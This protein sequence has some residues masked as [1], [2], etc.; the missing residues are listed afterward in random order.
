MRVYWTNESYPE[1]RP[2]P[3]R[4][5]RHR[6]WW[7]AFWLVRRDPRIYAFLLIVACILVVF[8]WLTELLDDAIRARGEAEV[9]LQT[10]MAVLAVTLSGM[11][12]LTWGGYIMRLHL[13]RASDRCRDCCPN[14]GYLLSGQL[15]APAGE[16]GTI[17]CPECGTAY[18]ASE[19]RA[20]QRVPPP[21]Q[22]PRPRYTGGGSWQNQ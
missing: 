5:L 11:L 2:L 16:S 15:Q 20:L 8:V 7:R 6:V 10:A 1:M 21:L 13:R 14:C 17:R 4:W 12:F 18:E 19:F 22:T 9:I 3:S